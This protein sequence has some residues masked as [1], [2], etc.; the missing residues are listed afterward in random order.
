MLDSGAQILG[1]ILSR[2]CF[3][4]IRL[5]DNMSPFHQRSLNPICNGDVLVDLAGFD[6]NLRKNS[7]GLKK[8]T[9]S[10]RNVLQIFMNFIQNLKILT[11]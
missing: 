2:T 9:Y 3:W 6:V 1:Q 5:E 8:Y 10:C 4:R 11:L 7:V